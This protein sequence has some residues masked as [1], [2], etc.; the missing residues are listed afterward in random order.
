MS[1]AG[2]VE[3][4]KEIKKEEFFHQQQRQRLIEYVM[5]EALKVGRRTARPPVVCCPPLVSTVC[6]PQ[7]AARRPPQLFA[8]L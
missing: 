2:Y 3:A 8:C 4:L 7:L 6:P 1:K 5:N